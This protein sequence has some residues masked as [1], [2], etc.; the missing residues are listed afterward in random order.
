MQ[1]D[2]WLNEESETNYKILRM[3][4]VIFGATCSPFL[5]AA[6][7]NHHAL[8]FKEEFPRV[9]ELVNKC[10]YVDDLVSG[11]DSE[12]E[13]ME[14]Y[15]DMRN[16]MQKASFNMRKW[17]TN[18]ESLQRKWEEGE[19]ANI[20]SSANSDVNV[21]G[22]IWENKEDVM[23][24]SLPEINLN[25][26]QV[27][28]KILMLGVIGRLYG[29]IGFIDPFTVTSKVLKQDCWRAGLE[30]DSPFSIR[31][32]PRFR[33]WCEDFVHL[34]EIK[35]DRHYFGN[36]NFADISDIQL[37]CF[38]DSSVQAYG[39]VIYHPQSTGLLG[40]PEHLEGT[41]RSLGSL[42]APQPRLTLEDFL[43]ASVVLSLVRFGK[44]GLDGCLQIGIQEFSRWFLSPLT[45]QQVFL[46]EPPPLILGERPQVDWLSH[47]LSI[48]WQS[49]QRLTEF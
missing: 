6:T 25:P 5:L 43:L 9:Y 35:I 44:T 1:I 21:L 33:C 11:A 3:T 31:I 23:K 17:K 2:L 48:R 29:P 27:I 28:T 4:R 42:A 13:A 12:T 38:T 41:R 19:N 15:R 40:C 45:Y 32:Q 10:M 26:D 49:S 14:I 39:A 7:L 20:I 47:D 34:I 30:L 36:S 37:H 8:K 24:F 18:S 22:Y 46:E 16:V